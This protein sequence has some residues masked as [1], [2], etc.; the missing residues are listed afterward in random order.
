MDLCDFLQFILRLFEK[1]SKNKNYFKHQCPY[2]ICR[3]LYMSKYLG[4]RQEHTMKHSLD[5]WLRASDNQMILSEIPP[6]T[7]QLH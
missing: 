2:L 1:Y 6:Y 7:N 5:S 3:G 4:L